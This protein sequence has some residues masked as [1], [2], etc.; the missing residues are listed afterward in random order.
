LNTWPNVTGT[1]LAA[2]DEVFV[3]LTVVISAAQAH[4][5]AAK[6]ATAPA[7]AR[8]EEILFMVMTR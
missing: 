3:T 2:D 8:Q 4:V 5:L 1:L 6:S 7:S